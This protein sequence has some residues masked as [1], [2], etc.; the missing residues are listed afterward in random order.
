MNR[1]RIATFDLFGLFHLADRVKISSIS[2]ARI[3][4][5]LKVVGIWLNILKKNDE[6]A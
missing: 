5:N 6:Q 2:N 1:N 3:W 4:H